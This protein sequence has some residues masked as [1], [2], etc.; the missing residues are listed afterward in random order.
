MEP[1]LVYRLVTANTVDQKV[2]ERAAAKGRLEKL[3]I[4]KGKFKTWIKSFSKS[5]ASVTQEELMEL[6]RSMD[7]DAEMGISDTDLRSLLD[8]SDLTDKWEKL[9]QGKHCDSQHEFDES[10]VQLSS[11]KQ[12]ELICS[13]MSVSAKSKIF[14]RLAKTYSS[15]VVFCLF[16]GT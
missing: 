9:K 16:M 5:L 7:F 6:L 13:F 4:H 3:V 11:H 12:P 10:D 8:C 2:V 14:V 15:P 1:V